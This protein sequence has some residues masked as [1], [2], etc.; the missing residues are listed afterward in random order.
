[1][2]EPGHSTDCGRVP[3]TNYQLR[4]GR[5]RAETAK[6]MPA[7]MNGLS[8]TKTR[9]N[10]D[11]NHAGP[12]Q[13]GTEMNC[14]HFYN[15][16]FTINR[17][18]ERLIADM[19]EVFTM[20]QKHLFSSTYKTGPHADTHTQM[21]VNPEFFNRPSQPRRETSWGSESSWIPD[22]RRKRVLCGAAPD[23]C[24]WFV[25]QSHVWDS[26]FVAEFGW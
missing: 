12:M 14:G 13:E 25:P 16:L 8:G 15:C 24:R 22:R 21:K 2:L 11:P 9:L 6:A 20:F 1:M 19:Q 5:S 7:G 23:N 10:S 3:S 26:W 18:R 17:H 4:F